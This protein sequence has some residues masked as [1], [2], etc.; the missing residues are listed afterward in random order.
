LNGLFLFHSDKLW[1]TLTDQKPLYEV[2][3]DD[4]EIKLS[5]KD[6]QYVCNVVGQQLQPSNAQLEIY[7][8]VELDYKNNSFRDLVLEI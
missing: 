1:C 6:Y 3:S 4:C 7:R 8:Y 5:F 2:I